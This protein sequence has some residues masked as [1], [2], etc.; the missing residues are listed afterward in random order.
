[1]KAKAARFLPATPVLCA[2]LLCGIPSSSFARAPVVEILSPTEY[3][4]PLPRVHARFTFGEEQLLRE[5]V[6]AVVD[7]VEV[8]FDPEND[9]R[10]NDGDDL[11][12][13]AGESMWS[14]LSDTSATMV[15]WLPYSLRSDDPATPANE[16]IHTIRIG[17][18][19]T[20]REWGEDVKQFEVA[21][22]LAALDAHCY[23]NPFNPEETSTQVR[24]TLTSSAKLTIEVYD[25]AGNRLATVCKDE[26]RDAG[27]QDESCDHWWG[28]DSRTDRR[29]PAGIYFVK[30]VAD[31][32]GQTQSAVAP[33]GVLPPR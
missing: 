13:E 8:R 11:I 3:A 19:N 22:E 23:P 10:D 27:I 31:R 25:F 17:V 12:D 5:T 24:F 21:A 20:L 26:W 2:V 28:R 32:S 9:G 18:Y 6:Q 29:V 7:E 1:V 15:A 16:G 14:E 30:I 33:V 4:P